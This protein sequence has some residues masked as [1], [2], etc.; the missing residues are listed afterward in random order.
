MPLRI[1]ILFRVKYIICIGVFFL[2]YITYSW[3]ETLAQEFRVNSTAKQG[4]KIV[5]IDKRTRIM[6]KTFE[7]TFLHE[8]VYEISLLVFFYFGFIN[9]QQVRQV[10]F[11][12]IKLAVRNL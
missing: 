3:V 10:I 9:S 6:W 4:M 11:K 2:I 1:N 8:I 7:C 5:H 12:F